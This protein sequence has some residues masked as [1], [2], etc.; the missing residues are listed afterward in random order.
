MQVAE[1]ERGTHQTTVP[2]RFGGSESQSIE[3]PQMEKR[4]GKEKGTRRRREG[5]T[6]THTRSKGAGDTQTDSGRTGRAGKVGVSEERTRP[7]ANSVVGKGLGGL[8]KC[9][10]PANKQTSNFKPLQQIALRLDKIQ[11]NQNAEGGTLQT[12]SF[13]TK[14]FL[15]AKTRSGIKRYRPQLQCG[16]TKPS[17]VKVPRLLRQVTP[18][19]ERQ[20]GE[21]CYALTSP[22]HCSTRPTPNRWLCPRRQPPDRADGTAALT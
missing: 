15:R 18:E 12:V 19:F 20:L 22:S 8:L 16:S 17:K 11:M 13:L 10:W 7:G 2:V 14:S 1:W 21:E 6:G 9:G 5:I 3:R 4:G